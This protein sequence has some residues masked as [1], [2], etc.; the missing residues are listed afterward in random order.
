MN[1]TKDKKYILIESIITLEKLLY[2]IISKPALYSSA[3]ELIKC[4]KS[5]GGIA[6]LSGEYAIEGERTVCLTPMSLNT[7]KL[8]ADAALGG[9]FKGLDTL[10][11]KA[12]E[13]CTQPVER[14]AR[15][16]KRTKIGLIHKVS[17]LE[18]ELDFHKKS[19]F[20]L[21]QALTSALS[22]FNNI[23]DA[24][25]APLRTKRAQDATDTLRA[26]IS[27]SLIS[28]PQAYQYTQTLSNSSVVDMSH[29][30]GQP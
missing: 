15:S 22:D 29:Y 13:S 4:L 14:P 7:L 20:I 16:N 6:S 18:K 9:G 28:E 26:I 12:L 24:T 21:L 5:Q 30:R 19:I 1:S 8:H 2:H 10:R 11:K 17:E 27:M 23:R 25:A 3:P